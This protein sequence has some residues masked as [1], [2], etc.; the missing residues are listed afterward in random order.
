[1]L[2]P[3]Y[4]SWQG[5]KAPEPEGPPDSGGAVMKAHPA[6]GAAAAGIQPITGRLRPPAP[7]IRGRV[8]QVKGRFQTCNNT[9]AFL[10]TPG[11]SHLEALA[12]GRRLSPW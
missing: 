9:E 8:S 12:A 11:S 4:F 5:G 2:G 3:I 10:E 7:R 6:A 1:M